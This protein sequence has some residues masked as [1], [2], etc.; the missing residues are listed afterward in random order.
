MRRGPLDVL[1][2]WG[3]SLSSYPTHHPS[4]YD[5]KSIVES[6]LEHAHEV[7][8]D[9][10]SS[11]TTHHYS[12]IVEPKSKDEASAAVAAVIHQ[13]QF[14]TLLQRLDLHTNV[15]IHKLG[16]GYEDDIFQSLDVDHDSFISFYDFSSWYERAQSL[17]YENKEHDSI[18]STKW[19][20]ARRTI[21]DFDQ[22]PISPIILRNA[23][24]CAITAPN[25][26][27][28]E[29]CRFIHVGPQTL[30]RFFHMN[31]VEIA[32]CLDE[33]HNSEEKESRQVL[34]DS[35][36]KKLKRWSTI[37]GWCVVTCKRSS[38]NKNINKIIDHPPTFFQN[39]TEEEDFAATCC[40]I[41][42][43]MLYLTSQGIGSKWVT[44]PIMKTGVFAELCGIQ[45]QEEKLVGCIWYGYAKGG[46]SNAPA[47]PRRKSV[48]DVLT[49]LA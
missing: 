45:E 4:K 2:L 36:Q 16:T 14:K 11:T 6:R 26:R 8:L 33:E 48:Y 32:I 49:D 19:I 34:I 47:V 3:L 31:P 35:I 5:V 22:T 28:T 25:H 46:L 30:N 44:G 24:Q 43:M 17:L 18:E 12:F 27:L 38:K 9:L 13:S 40:A 39:E 41:Q 37:P 20:T 23:I 29:P 10:G 7:F 15:L 42:N 21:H 1:F